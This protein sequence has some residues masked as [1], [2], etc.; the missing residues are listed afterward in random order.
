MPQHSRREFLKTGLAAG[1][2][3]VGGTEPVP[4]G[5]PPPDVGCPGAAGVPGVGDGTGAAGVPPAGD[6]AGPE[7]R[8]RAAAGPL[9]TKIGVNPENGNGAAGFLTA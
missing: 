8:P 5:L 2:L 9:E 7:P 4:P 1:A 6:V 3:A